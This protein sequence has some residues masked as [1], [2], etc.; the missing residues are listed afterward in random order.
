MVSGIG[1]DITEI[2]RIRKLYVEYGSIFLDRVFTKEE[3]DYCLPMADPVPSLAARWAAKEAF[4]KALPASCKEHGTWRGVSVIKSEGGIPSFKVVDPKLTQALHEEAI[5]A[6]HLSISHEKSHALA[7]V[8]MEKQ[9][10]CDNSSS[11]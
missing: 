7:F 9:L 2:A 1:T 6:I 5:S 4:Y 10:W 3:Q 8:I 11:D